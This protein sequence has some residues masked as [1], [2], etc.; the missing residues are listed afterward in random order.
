MRPRFR[1]IA[2]QISSPLA[3]TLAL[4][5]LAASKPKSH[6]VKRATAV[7]DEENYSVA[8][9]TSDLVQDARSGASSLEKKAE[10]RRAAAST[11]KVLTALVV[12]EDGFLDR[13]VVV[14]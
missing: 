13:T 9:Q 5:C 1:R 11:Q 10:A 12:A 7:A 4:L 2:A 6:Q 14:E 8:Y 3:I